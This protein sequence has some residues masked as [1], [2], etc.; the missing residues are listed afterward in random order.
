M[1]S[2]HVSLCPT[3]YVR[4]KT[5]RLTWQVDQPFGD[6]DGS[7][8]NKF[9]D[10][11][12]QQRHLIPE[13]FQAYYTE[14]LKRGETVFDSGGCKGLEVT[15]SPIPLFP[16]LLHEGLSHGGP[17]ARGDSARQQRLQK[18]RGDKPSM[19]LDFL[20]VQLVLLLQGRIGDCPMAGLVCCSRAG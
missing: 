14:A 13:A 9:W 6:L 15:A 20:T 19:P 4:L 5:C 16:G 2:G 18:S 7:H 1:A 12:S 10:F 17:E 3:L 8:V 11:G